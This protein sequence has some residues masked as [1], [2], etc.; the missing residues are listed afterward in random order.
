M[1]LCDV[2]LRGGRI[3]K[4]HARGPGSWGSGEII[5]LQH[6]EHPDVVRPY[7]GLNPEDFDWNPDGTLSHWR[8]FVYVCISRVQYGSVDLKM[9][10]EPEYKSATYEYVREAQAADFREAEASLNT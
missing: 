2:N 6:K 9:K 10:G 3:G 7:F 1:R 5:V 4:A 8:A